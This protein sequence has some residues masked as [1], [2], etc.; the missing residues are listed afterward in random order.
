MQIHSNWSI[1]TVDGIALRRD[2]ATETHRSFRAHISADAS[3]FIGRCP[4]VDKLYRVGYC[5]V[6]V[7][8]IDKLFAVGTWKVCNSFP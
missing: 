4:V 8:V 5:A 1:Q 6:L 2:E 7:A 3:R